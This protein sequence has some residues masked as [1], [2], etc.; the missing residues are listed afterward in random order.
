MHK[1]MRAYKQGGEL[2]KALEQMEEIISFQRK[3]DSSN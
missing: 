3:F 1:L 2:Q